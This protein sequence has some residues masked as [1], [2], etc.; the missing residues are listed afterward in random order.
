MKFLTI[1]LLVFLTLTACQSSSPDTTP[2]IESV[3][4]PIV[5]EGYPAP[6]PMNS[7]E[8]YPYS[9]APAVSNDPYPALQAPMVANDP[10]AAPVDKSISI[11]WDELK[12]MILDGQIAQVTQLHSLSVTAIHKDGTVFFTVEP[13]IDAVF[14]VLDECGDICK[15]VIRATE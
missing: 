13:E 2:E 7:D 10:Y 12:I 8:P 11:T 6:E 14:A 9:Q 5:E 1:L 15:D 4:Q 3:E